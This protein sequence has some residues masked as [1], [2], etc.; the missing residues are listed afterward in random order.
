MDDI[1]KI[2]VAGGGI[3][4]TDTA[5]VIDLTGGSPSV[6]S[7][8]SMADA[9]RQNNLTVLADGTVLVTGGLSSKEPLVDLNAGVYAA[10]LWNPATGQWK[11]LSNMRVTRQYHSTALLL[12]DGR[13]LSAGGGI[14]ATCNAIGYLNKNAEIF[15]PPYLFAKNGSGSLAPRPTVTAAPSTVSEGSQFTV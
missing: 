10:E 14:C 13:V 11:T 8:G 7:T 1:G 12:P 2:L 15:S 9:R 6:A 4:P 5:K 3:P